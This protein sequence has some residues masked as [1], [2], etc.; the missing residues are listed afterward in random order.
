MIKLI[1]SNENEAYIS[2]LR[3]LDYLNAEVKLEKFNKESLKEVKDYLKKKRF[4][5]IYVGVSRPNRTDVFTKFTQKKPLAPRSGH[6]PLRAYQE[7]SNGT[8]LYGPSGF[9]ESEEAIRERVNRSYNSKLS[10][11]MRSKPIR[12][13]EETFIGIKEAIIFIAFAWLLFVALTGF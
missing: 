1:D 9:K 13:V 12:S 7:D 4:K 6:S 3:N 10:K 5:L 2:D 8:Y 11:T